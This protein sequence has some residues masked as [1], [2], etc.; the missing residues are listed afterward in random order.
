MVWPPPPD[1][2]IYAR[3]GPAYPVLL[4]QLLQWEVNTVSCGI[5]GDQRE[6]ER[7]REL[8]DL[9]LSVSEAAIRGSFEIINTN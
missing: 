9:M 8:T 1:V 7:E 5:Y 4:F 6:R 2:I 3:E